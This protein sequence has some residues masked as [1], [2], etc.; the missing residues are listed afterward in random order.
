EKGGKGRKAWP[1]TGDRRLDV[2]EMPLAQTELVAHAPPGV[3]VGRNIDHG[4]D[5]AT[6]HEL[7][8]DPHQEIV[9]AELDVATFGAEPDVAAAARKEKSNRLRLLGSLG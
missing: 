5:N 2:G 4:R 7:T 1:E 9:L 6:L 8:P 3:L